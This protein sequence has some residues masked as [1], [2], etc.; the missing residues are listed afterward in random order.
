MIERT[1]LGLV[2]SGDEILTP[3][4]RLVGDLFDDYRAALGEVEFWRKAALGEFW[5]EAVD[6]H[7][8]ELGYKLRYEDE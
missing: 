4:G 1:K 6:E 7:A 2:I 3:I 5:Q 8:F